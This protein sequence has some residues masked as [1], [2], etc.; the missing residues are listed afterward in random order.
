MANNKI[1]RIIYLSQLF[2]PEPTFKGGEFIKQ[3]S[4][5]GYKIEVVTGY[6]NYPGG[7]IYS[8]YKIKPI[9]REFTNDYE[10]TR[11]AMYPSHNR[12][13]IKRILCYFSFML[14]SV[15]YLMLMAKRYEIIYVYY[16]ALTAGLAAIAAKLI[17]GTP[18]ILD[19]QDMWPDSLSSSEMVKSRTVINLANV[20]CDLLYRNCDHIIVLS[21]GFKELLIKRGVLAEK[22]TV[23]YNWA[24]ENISKEK[25]RVPEDFIDAEKFKVLFAGNIGAAQH[26]DTVISAA[27]LLHQSHPNI[28]FYIMGEGIDKER[29]IKLAE[30]LELPNV[31]FLPRVP[32]DEVQ[33]Y[34]SASDA[35]LVH[36]KDNPLFSI[37]IPSKTQA[38]LFSQ[39]P[40][41]MGVAGD[42]SSLI[43]EAEAGYIFTPCDPISLAESVKQLFNDT[44]EKREKFGRNAKKY[45]MENLQQSIGIKKTSSIIERF[46]S[47]KTN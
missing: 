7:K 32:L 36:L 5:N 15:L 23:I 4:S 6:P 40:L 10:I 1:P 14:S 46:R 28:I 9:K 45:Y 34:L 3:L 35:L 39:R 11:L 44:P 25:D 20:A 26:L 22:I 29:L 12:S 47:D 33:F 30:D 43:R 42:A 17:R 24:E 2:D 19:I 38:Y 16:P 13:A 27:N 41:L 37:T 8:G 31:K 18:V 21:P